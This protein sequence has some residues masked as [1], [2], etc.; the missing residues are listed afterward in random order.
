MARAHLARG[1]EPDEGLRVAVVD[2]IDRV[3][4]EGLDE[5]RRADC[6]ARL[7]GSWVVWGLSCARRVGCFGGL[8]YAERV[9]CQVPC[10]RKRFPTRLREVWLSWG[11]GEGQ[12]EVEQCASVE[13][14]SHTT[15]AAR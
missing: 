12:G 8:A 5:A 1:L 13:R 7:L 3:A 15:M 10:A 4:V 6:L 9:G 14:H 2:D 11:G